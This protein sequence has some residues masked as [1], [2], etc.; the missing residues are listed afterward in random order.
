M[1]VTSYDTKA[2]KDDIIPPFT[3]VPGSG[4]QLGFGNHTGVLTQ[5]GSRSNPDPTWATDPGAEQGFDTGS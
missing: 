4:L 1:I 2:H 5:V 3:R